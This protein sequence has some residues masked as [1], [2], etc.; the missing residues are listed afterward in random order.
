[1][2]ALFQRSLL[3][4]LLMGC[5]G[6]NTTAADAGANGPAD[7][8]SPKADVITAT[9]ANPDMGETVNGGVTPVYVTFVSHNERTLTRF[10]RFRENLSDYKIWRASVIRV[11]K[12]IRDYGAKYSWQTDYVIIEGIETFESQ[13]LASD[14]A[15]TNGKPILRYLKEDLGVSIEPHAHECDLATNNNCKDKK[16]NYADLAQLIKTIG[17]VDPAPI[18]GG[19]TSAE[20]TLAAWESCIKGN[21]F[22]ITWCPEALT[23]FAGDQGGHNGGDD[24]HSGVWYPSDLTT[25][26]L[27]HNTSGKLAY[28]GSSYLFSA[29]FGLSQSATLEPLAFIQS[30]AAKLKSGELEGNR[31]Y[32]ASVMLIEDHM[33]DKD[34]YGAVENFLKQ[35]KPLIDSGQVVSATYPEVLG[36]WKTTYTSNPNIYLM[37]P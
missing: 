11:A 10:G 8:Q 1:M 34:Q 14:S 16:Y 36:I 37:S 5:G 33:I 26:F 23:V 15:A 3:C 17:G 31:I 6:K 22:S 13:V 29:D 4:L 27:A 32:T 21:V 25:G 2:R 28:I 30:C 24:Y 12:M 18:I 7:T 35:L 9:D 19:S 20:R